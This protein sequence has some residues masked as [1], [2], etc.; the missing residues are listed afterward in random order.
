M[1]FS[2]KISK[3]RDFSTYYYVFFHIAC[4]DNM[5][6]YV[7]KHFVLSILRDRDM[8]H[9]CMHLTHA[10]THNG[11][12]WSAPYEINYHPIPSK[13]PLMPAPVRLWCS[14][15]NFQKSAKVFGT[16]IDISGL[17]ARARASWSNRSIENLSPRYRIHR[18]NAHEH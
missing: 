10:C 7:E 11:P 3:Y 17:G 16:G 15:A 9:S 14:R 6:G 5:K 8:R 18:R 12:S 4:K 1:I 13:L 2:T